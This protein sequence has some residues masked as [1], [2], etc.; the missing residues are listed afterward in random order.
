MKRKFNWLKSLC[1]PF[2][3]EQHSSYTTPLRKRYSAENILLNTAVKTCFEIQKS[4]EYV[5]IIYDSQLP[6]RGSLR[7]TTTSPRA[8]Q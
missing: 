3:Y 4:I 1:Y 5:N 8:S 2:S 6:L 7:R